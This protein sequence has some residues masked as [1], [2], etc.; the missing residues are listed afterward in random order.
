MAE[1]FDICVIGGCGH[2]GLPLGLSFAT[3]GKKVVLFDINQDSVD[4][5]NDKIMPFLDEGTPEA[6]VQTIDSG[7]L[8]ATAD[9]S[10]ISASKNIILVVGTPVDQHLNPKLRDVVDV[11]KGI[12]GH[13]KK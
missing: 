5:V 7:V 12:S 4:K 9:P 1:N 3:H 10:V 2:V 6:L 8:K 11:I 13:L